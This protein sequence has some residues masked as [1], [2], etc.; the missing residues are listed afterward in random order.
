VKIISDFPHVGR[1]T[2]QANI[3]VKIV[4]DYLM[5]YEVSHTQI[6][7]LTIWDSRQNPE[8]LSKSLQ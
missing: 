6:T 3:R 7:I 2:D 1:Q 8:A 5:I 4:K